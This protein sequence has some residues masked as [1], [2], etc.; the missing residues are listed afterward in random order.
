MFLFS[1]NSSAV[2]N[3]VPLPHLYSIPR[4]DEIC[5]CHK[6]ETN[7]IRYRWKSRA[8]KGGRTQESGGNFGWHSILTLPRFLVVVLVHGGRGS[9]RRCGGWVV[10]G[11]S[12]DIF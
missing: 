7:T 10:G 11:W 1:A 5:R 12:G 4:M 9:F 3:V 8:G 6:I 2:S